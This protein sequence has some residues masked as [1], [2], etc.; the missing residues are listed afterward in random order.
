MKSSSDDSKMSKFR[1]LGSSSDM[2]SP[3]DL[4]EGVRERLVEV[5]LVLEEDFERPERR[6][7]GVSGGRVTVRKLTSCSPA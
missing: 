3:R 7:M 5:R 4:L 2:L 1:P 6:L